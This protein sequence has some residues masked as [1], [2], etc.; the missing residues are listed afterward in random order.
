[1]EEIKIDQSEL[2]N[3]S[4]ATPEE[5]GKFIK[6]LRV[7]RNLKQ[8]ELADIIG[9]VRQTVSNWESGKSEVDYTRATLLASVFNVHALEI[10]LAKRLTVQEIDEKIKE[11]YQEVQVLKKQKKN[12][13]KVLITTFI[14][15]ILLFLLYY[16]LN[17]YNSIKIYNVLLDDSNYKE[18]I[19][20]FFVS[21]DFIYFDLD[22]RDDN[23]K[24]ITLKNIK[25]NETNHILYV[26]DSKLTIND[27]YGYEAYFKYEDIIKDKC[28][29]FIVIEYKEGNYKQIGLKLEKKYENKKLL[30][31]KKKKIS[32]DIQVEHREPNIPIKIQE[33]LKLEGDFYNLEIKTDVKTIYLNYSIDTES[34]FVT[35]EYKNYIDTWT[36]NADANELLY[37]RSNTKNKII[38]E[39]IITKE[40][41]EKLYQYFFE[42]YIK[43][44]I[45]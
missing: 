34:F 9:V 7:K 38:E 11:T 33:K 32:N 3:I 37:N 6:D 5:I 18:N 39:K 28:E 19:G 16:F 36:Y 14:S 24:S 21:K 31:L 29:Y 10:L 20:I 15:L 42:N 8:G 23:I 25:D 13:I 40:N 44:Y 35:E 22:L 43:E 45:E 2:S 30:L 4:S 41:D 12:V 17:S 26:D 1:M 27:F